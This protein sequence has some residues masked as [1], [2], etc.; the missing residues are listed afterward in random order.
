MI[1]IIG[2]IERLWLRKLSQQIANFMKYLKSFEDKK[3]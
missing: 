2:M 3:R 1:G